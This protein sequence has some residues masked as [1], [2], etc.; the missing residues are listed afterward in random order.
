MNSFQAIYLKSTINS[1]ISPMKIVCMKIESVDEN[2][3]TKSS[4]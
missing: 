3:R 4:R 2:R 1:F